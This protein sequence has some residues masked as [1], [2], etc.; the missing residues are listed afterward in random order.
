MAPPAS[1]DLFP[2]FLRPAVEAALSDTRVVVIQGARQVGKSTLAGQILRGRAGARFVTLD[3]PEVLAA[4]RADPVTFVR[5]DGLLAID[6]IQRAPELLLPI[7][8]RVDADP[9]PGQFLLTGPAHLLSLPR[10]SDALAGR[11]EIVELWPLS[12]GE[13]GGR[14]EAFIDRLFE[15]R[16]ESATPTPIGREEVFTRACAGGFPE[17]RRRRGARRTAWFT[18]Y[19]HTFATRDVRDLQDIEHVRRLR[20]LLALL[21]ARV[22]SPLNVDDLGRDARLASST[23]RRYVD[24]LEAA[25]LLLRLPAWSTNRSQR[26]ASSP[27]CYPAD[28]GLCAHLLGLE[29]TELARPGAAAGP[30]LETFVVT[31]LRKQL[32]WSTTRVELH[33]LRTRD[34]PEVDVVLEDPAGRVA[35]VEVKSS[36]TVGAR[37]FAGLRWLRARAGA[38][39]TQGVVLY[40]GE[41]VLPFGPD[42]WALPLPALWA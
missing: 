35:G 23:T 27:K 28:A 40:T 3:D 5:H 30:V 33:H 24:L 34:G 7:K 1:P 11:L 25:Y 32:G 36:A 12:Q 19:L 6:E 29:P 37:D 14:R 42:L 15:R 13:I 18:A 26:V 16:A 17:A 8:A 39:F 4:A 10:V 22:G 9:R 31:E 2:R 20:A 38:S 41:H 21:A